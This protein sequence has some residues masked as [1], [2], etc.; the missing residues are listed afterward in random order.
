LLGL[1]AAGPALAGD[2]L[3]LERVGGAWDLSEAADAWTVRRLDLSSPIGSVKAEGTLTATPGATT[4]IAGR[5]DLAALARQLPHA[6]RLRDGL[7]LERGLAQI[8]ADIRSEAAGQTLDVEARVSDLIA[9]DV[10]RTFALNDPATVSAQLTRRAGRLGVGRIAARSAFLDASG[11]GDLERGVALTGSLDLGRLQAQLRDLID[12]G[13]LEIAGRALLSASYRRTGATFAAQLATEFHDLSLA[14]LAGAPFRRDLVQLDCT[15]GGPASGTGL[16]G[17]WATVRLGLKAADIVADLTAS[18]RDAATIGLTA[19]AASPV[20][21]AARAGLAEGRFAGSWTGRLLQ[22]DEVRVGLRPEDPVARADDAMRL[23]VGTQAATPA[24]PVGSLALA[25]R[26]RFDAATGDLVLGPL[27]GAEPEAISLSADGLSVSGLGRSGGLLQ[28]TL[29]LGGDLA[30]LDGAMAAWTG[31]AGVGLSGNGSV[32][33]TASKGQDGGLLL[34]GAI[35]TRDLALPAAAGLVVDRGDVR[36]QVTIRPDGEGRRVDVEARIAELVAHRPAAS[37]PV[38]LRDPAT[39]TARIANRG[40]AIAVA[41]V[42]VKSAF[43]DATGSG[44]LERGVKLTGTLDL[45]TLRAQMHDL[46]DLNGLDA[47]GAGR[48]AADYRRAGAT[49]TGRFAAEFPE[50]TLTGLSSQPLRREAVRLDASV[51]GPAAGSG[52]PAGWTSARAGLKS[53]ALAARL[54]A[55]PRDAAIALAATASGSIPTRGGAARVEAQ[56]VGRWVAPALELDTIRLGLRPADARTP[57][58]SI[59]LAARGRFDMA[60]GDLVLEPDP[61]GAPGSLAPLPEGLHI[62]GLGQA[63]AAVTVGG[64]LS[65]DLAPLDGALATWTGGVPRGLAGALTARVSARRDQDGRLFVGAAL[66]C[67]DLSRLAAD[68]RGRR[69]EGPLS[70]GVRAAYQPDADRVELTELVLKGRPGT[71]RA[72]GSLAEPTGRLLADVTGTLAPDWA[73][74][75]ALVAASVEPGARLRGTPR[76]FRLKGPLRGG[77]AA[78]VLRGLDAE[79]GLDLSEAQAFGLRLGPTPL[80]VRCGGGNV[81]IEPIETTLNGGRAS[82]RPEVRLDDPRGMILRLSPGSAIT[83]AEID[84]EVSRRVLAYVAPILHESTQVRGH[85]SAVFDRAEFPLGGGAASSAAAEGRVTFQDVV[86]GPGPLAQRLLQLVGRR[87]TASLRLDRTVSF[88]IADGRVTQNGLAIDVG[89]K[90]QIAL[91]GSVGFDGTLALRAGVPITAAMLGNQGLLS[92][93][94]DGTRVGVPIGGTLA[95][96]GIDQRAL[97]VALREAGRSVV[98]RGVT[99]GAEGLLQRLAPAESRAG[100]AGPGGTPSRRPGGSSLPEEAPRFLRP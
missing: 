18:H 4:R 53:G 23:R 37:R 27:P 96:P 17:G 50:L 19:A 95:H 29:G 94:V 38:S 86:Y 3:R 76:P 34:T 13:G 2:R 40:D 35:D 89:P 80:V 90:V 22:I 58:G 100:A 73:R 68:G 43:L 8:R 44:D 77:S 51:T 88:A 7:T 16:P 78:E 64:G 41:G 72:S 15:A 75:N 63:G 69:G 48:F 24:V 74:V 1:D 49:Y 91:D 61:R 93:A 32:R 79:F 28:G 55:A 82:L 83:D 45:A 11:S 6:L 42:T 30:R 60:R 85:L 67:P 62:A 57:S 52:A 39:V 12:F 14:G 21:L 9:R 87:A 46:V 31:G 71:L 97:E 81:A 66:D 65:S 47:A 33:M 26:G 20:R 5:L 59:S 84:D 92:E 10:A 36:V 98:R 25:A 56:L 70:L 99:A 54:T